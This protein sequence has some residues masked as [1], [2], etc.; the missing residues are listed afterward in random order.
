MRKAV[1]VP[2][3][4]PRSALGLQ[5]SSVVRKG[6]TVY[7]DE[8]IDVDAAIAAYAEIDFAM[9]NKSLTSPS[10]PV[11]REDLNAVYAKPLG[12]GWFE[13]PGGQKVQGLDNVPYQMRPNV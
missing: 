8:D 3:D 12:G 4:I 2:K 9:V 1:T 10:A 5:G 11:P 7:V 6:Q 13:L